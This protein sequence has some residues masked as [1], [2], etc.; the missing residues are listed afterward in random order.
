MRVVRLSVAERGLL[1]ARYAEHGNS[2]VRLRAAL[3]EAGAAAMAERLTAL[4]GLERRFD[5]DLGEVCHRYGRRLHPDTHAIERSIVEFIARP[6]DGEDDGDLL[7]LL[8]HL[9]QVRDLMDGRLVEEA[10]EV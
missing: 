6:A 8:D 9:D 1:A 7:V 3:L 10:E 5:V 4:R 2:T